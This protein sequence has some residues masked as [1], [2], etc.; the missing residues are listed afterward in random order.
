MC[1]VRRE[2]TDDGADY[3]VVRQTNR[4]EDTSDRPVVVRKNIS[5]T[6]QPAEANRRKTCGW[7]SVHNADLTSNQHITISS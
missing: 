3:K 4:N 2:R 7:A 5:C 1:E 6:I